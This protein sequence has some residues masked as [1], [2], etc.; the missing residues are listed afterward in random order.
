MSENEIKPVLPGAI[1]RVRWGLDSA[2][3]IV[4]MDDV[5]ELL[6]HIDRLT[7]DAASL[8]ERMIELERQRDDYLSREW[9]AEKAKRKAEAERDT[10][11]KKYDKLTGERFSDRVHAALKSRTEQAEAERDAAVA[12]AER[13]NWLDQQMAEGCA[14]AI[15]NDDDGRWAYCD[16]GTSPVPEDG[17]HKEMVA[18]T[19]FADPAAWRPS[20]RD[21]IDAARSEGGV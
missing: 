17:G 2:V 13:L 14:P 11:Q 9:Q 1:E 6:A 20:I 18:I 19:A 12:D 16:S 8:R 7:A 5:R 21:A 3:G 4:Q 15:V 10:L